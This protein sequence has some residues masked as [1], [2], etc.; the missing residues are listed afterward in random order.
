MSK[1]RAWSPWYLRAA[2][3]R[4]QNPRWNRCENYTGAGTCRS[5]VSHRTPDA[6]FT[7]DRWCDSC[8]ITAAM[9]GTLR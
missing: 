5:M 6:D 1:L 3:R 4:V 8:I 7:A 2:M 9:E